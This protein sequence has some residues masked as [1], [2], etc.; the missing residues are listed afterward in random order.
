MS[1]KSIAFEEA[2]K[3][4][5]DASAKLK[6]QDV[7]LEEAIKSYEEGITHYKTCSEILDRAGQ[8]IE[9]LTKEV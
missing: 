6:S 4:L 9:S 5:E 8:K 1:E 3:K 2:L 7:S